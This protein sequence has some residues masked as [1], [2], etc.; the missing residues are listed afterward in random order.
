[1]IDAKTRQI[2]AEWVAKYDA[3]V[4]RED[5]PEMIRIISICES[6]PNRPFKK[7]LQRQ[8]EEV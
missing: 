2:V 8:L 3:A 6:S 5:L 7:E 1:M 4:Q